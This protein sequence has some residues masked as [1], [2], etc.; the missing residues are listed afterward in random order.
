M[1]CQ[2]NGY[3]NGLQ[4]FRFMCSGHLSG[5]LNIIKQFLDPSRLVSFGLRGGQLFAPWST[6]LVHWD[7]EFDKTA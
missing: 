5:Q 4:N 7:E 2:T 6:G 3:I 1:D